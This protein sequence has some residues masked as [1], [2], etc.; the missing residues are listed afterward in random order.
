MKDYLTLLSN[1]MHEGDHRG[2]RNG[3]TRSLFG[4]SLQFDLRRG[5]PVLTTKRMATKAIFGELIGF[6][7][8]YDNAR[9]F[10]ELGCRVWNANAESPYWVNSA[11]YRGEGDLGRIYGVQWRSWRTHVP[12]LGDQRSEEGMFPIEG[13]RTLDQIE[14][15]I[16][17]IRNDPSNRRMVVTAWNPAE[18]NEMALPPCHLFFQVYCEGQYM[19]LQMYQRSVDIFLGLPFNIASYATLLWILARHT[20]YE[21]RRLTMC[22][23]DTHLYTA[24]LEQA[25]EQLERSPRTLPTLHYDY[26]GLAPDLVAPASMHPE[27]F[28]LDNYEP[29]PAIKAEMLV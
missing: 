26:G 5:H 23:G 25:Y 17:L 8:G 14:R 15:L 19:D 28:R 1:V 16:R 2:T 21:P 22:L 20:G 27:R 10:E 9:D 24:H 18:L 13:Y 7:R 3:G 6:L 12:L 29:H 4:Q 11:A